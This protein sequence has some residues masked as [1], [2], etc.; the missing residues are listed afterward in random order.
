MILFIVYIIKI[1]IPWL[2]ILSLL[3]I[4]A[5]EVILFSGSHFPV[6]PLHV[7]F[8]GDLGGNSITVRWY[9]RKTNLHHVSATDRIVCYAT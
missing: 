6:Q 9:R 5:F 7:G 1:T 4:F 3:K 2:N 8:T